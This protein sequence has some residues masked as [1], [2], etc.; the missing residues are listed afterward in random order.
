MKTIGQLRTEVET[1]RQCLADFQTPIPHTVMERAT[2]AVAALLDECPPEH[3]FELTTAAHHAL[4][5]TTAEGVLPKSSRARWAMERKT[6]ET[7]D[8]PQ[9]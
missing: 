8:A 9:P 2:R 6:P 1:L 7:G 3:R 5:I 4:G